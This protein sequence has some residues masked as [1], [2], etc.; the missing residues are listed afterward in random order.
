MTE[1]PPRAPLSAYSCAFDRPV[2]LRHVE[3]VPAH[4]VWEITNAC[5]LD[6]VHC[7][8]E[9]G[10]AR[11]SELSTDEALALCDDLAA[12]GC[13]VVNLSGGEPFLRPDWSRICE[14]M[15]ALGM[16]P[17]IVSNL[18][19]PSQDHFATLARLGARWVATSLDGP[20]AVHDRIRRTR[21][22]TWSAFARTH[23]NVRDLK[24]RG[25]SVAVITHVSLWNL[26]HLDA[27]AEVLEE[28][29]VDQWQLQIGQPSG[30]LRE[31]ADS[32]LIY[33]RQIEEIYRFVL[34][35]QRRGRLA[36]DVADDIGFFGPEELE[37]RAL[38]GELRFFAGCQAGYRVL[39]I[40]SDG[41]VRGCP[42]LEIEVGNVRETPLAEIW[43]DESRFWFNHWDPSQIEGNCRRC[44]YQQ[45]CRCGCKSLALSTTGSLNRNIYCLNQIQSLGGDPDRREVGGVPLA[46]GPAEPES[47]E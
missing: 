35:V 31:I 30:R 27:L 3:R 47:A 11:A 17:V 29:G 2:A 34:R 13:Q 21:G 44:S 8:S 41:A 33:P 20:A 42:S 12:L 7:E 45:I 40:A 10:R 32:Y 24:A 46:S 18:T 28:L 25:F 14:R 5:N 43:K 1:A 9:S 23:A 39:A 16:E 6:C 19:I 22:E 4:C 38:A 26:P 36:L 15:V 37:V